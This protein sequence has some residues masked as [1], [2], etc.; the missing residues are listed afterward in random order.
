MK[1]KST[2]SPS[3][4]TNTQFL[5]SQETRKRMNDDCT[6]KKALKLQIACLESKLENAFSEKGVDEGK[7]FSDDLCC[8]HGRSNSTSATCRFFY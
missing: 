1:S 8:T 6:D 3:S 5:S 4:F 2:T 7:D